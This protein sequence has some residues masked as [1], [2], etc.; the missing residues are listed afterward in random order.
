MDT[1]DLQEEREARHQEFLI[2]RARSNSLELKPTGCCLSCGEEILPESANQRF[3]DVSCRN[4][5]DAKL[6]KTFLQG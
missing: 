5:Y 1:I 4:D 2:D 6:K 3:C